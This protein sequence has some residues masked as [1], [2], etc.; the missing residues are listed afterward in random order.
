MAGITALGDDEV[1][2]PRK[3][4]HDQ[5]RNRCHGIELAQA[6]QRKNCR[7]EQN[8]RDDVPFE[9]GIAPD[10][11]CCARRVGSRQSVSSAERDVRSFNRAWSVLY[12]RT[13]PFRSKRGTRDRRIWHR[14]V[15][16]SRFDCAVVLRPC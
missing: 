7:D 3:S 9:A 8:A 12:A 5:G 10:R 6:P 15:R 2:P 1:R 16:G 13:G 14:K 11:R 4:E